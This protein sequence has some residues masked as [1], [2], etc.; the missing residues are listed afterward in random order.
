MI[1][2]LMLA[3]AL[4]GAGTPPPASG[5]T[6]IPRMSGFLEWLPDGN[7]A[8]FIR[9]DTGRW[10]RATLDT[11]CPRLRQGARMRFN[12]SPGNRFDRH[13][14]IRADGWRCM[15]ASVTDSSGPPPR[16]H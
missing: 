16:R 9:G 1:A 3:L 15:V 8:L 14:S 2:P 5:E 10:Y 6:T 11:P 4:A 13:S 7:Q 12:A